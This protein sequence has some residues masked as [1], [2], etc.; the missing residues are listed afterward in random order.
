MPMDGE[1]ANAAGALAA[2]L[3]TMLFIGQLSF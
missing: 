2:W 1:G 3:F